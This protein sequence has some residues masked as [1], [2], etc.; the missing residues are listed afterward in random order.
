MTLVLRKYHNRREHF[1]AKRTKIFPVMLMVVILISSSEGIIFSNIIGPLYSKSHSSV[2]FG[3][4]SKK[5]SAA[6][7]YNYILAGKWVK[8]HVPPK[9]VFFTNRQCAE[10]V[11]SMNRCDGLWFYASALTR[12][13]FLIEGDGY[14]IKSGI[15]KA[16]RL[17]N[18][19]LSTRFSLNPSQRDSRALW[20]KNVR[21]GW[22]DR[23]VSQRID[24]GK[25]AQEVYSN[26]D[27]TIIQLLQPNK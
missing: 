18:Q 5:D 20:M 19:K 15:L 27:I 6:I 17:E 12:R 22:I 10:L 1:N 26:S 4:S 23:K 16:E 7:S 3:K 21:W 2:G 13:Q 25:F 24:W 14:A 11:T 9:E 8:N